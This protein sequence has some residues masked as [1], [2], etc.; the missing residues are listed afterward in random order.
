[1]GAVSEYATTVIRLFPDYADSV[2]WFRSPVPY[3]ETQFDAQ[4]IA[5]LRAWDAS[6][7]AGLTSDYEW[8][9]PELAAQFYVEGA[10]LARQ[11]ADQVGDDFEVE[12]DLGE[13]H[14]RVRGAG[15]ARNPDAAAAFRCLAD[16]ARVQR[17]QLQ[18][19]VD[20]AARDGHTLEWRAY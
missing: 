10:R 4:L 12:H 17:I 8:R 14:R 13:T 1:M 6:Y 11:V 19:V 5:E 20:E 16:A 15:P 9:T 7:Y 2:V 18:Q 3:E